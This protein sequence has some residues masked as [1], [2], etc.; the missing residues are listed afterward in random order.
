MVLL[1]FYE[2][3]KNQV[4][5]TFKESDHK[6]PKMSLYTDRVFNAPEEVSFPLIMFK[7]KDVNWQT[8][9]ERVYKAS[10]LFSVYIVDE[11]NVNHRYQNILEKANL[12]DVAILKH[13]TAEEIAQNQQD[14]ANGT[15]A[16]NLIPNSTQKISERQ[17]TVEDYPW[18]KNNYFIWEICYATTLVENAHRK[19]YTMLTDNAFSITDLQEEQKQQQISEELGRDGIDLAEYLP[20][21]DPSKSKII[22]Q[23]IKYSIDVNSDKD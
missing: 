18:E 14:I 12:V 5:K 17:C 15:V 7:Y 10:V 1:D 6:Y 3:V 20:L 4:K 11:P 13:P 19:K 21:E 23:S 2:Q 9:S 8:S 16:S 22:D